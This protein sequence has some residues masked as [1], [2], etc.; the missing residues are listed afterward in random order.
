MRELFRELVVGKR[1]VRLE[2]ERD[3]VQ[4]WTIGLRSAQ[5]TVGKL[6]ELSKLLR[7]MPSPDDKT[8]TAKHLVVLHMLSARYGI[9]LRKTRLRR[10]RA[11]G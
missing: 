5:A 11:D 4:A 3:T 8:T 2:Q 9:P 6:P 1:R 10:V 7:V